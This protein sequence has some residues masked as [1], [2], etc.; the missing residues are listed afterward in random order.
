MSNGKQFSKKMK[1]TKSG[2]TY[3]RTHGF[4]VPND[5]R[6]DPEEITRYCDRLG[7]PYV[8]VGNYYFYAEQCTAFGK[9]KHCW[10]DGTNRAVCL[11]NGTLKGY[12]KSKKSAEKF[13][14]EIKD[15]H[16]EN[17]VNY[18]IDYHATLDQFD[19][20]LNE[21]NEYDDEANEYDDY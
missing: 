20:S 15:G 17:V 4:P 21:A 16:H 10:W 7:H 6:N 1:N 9:R 5:C 13:L 12:F 19:K 8:V 2:H 3:W 11:K 14:A 18:I